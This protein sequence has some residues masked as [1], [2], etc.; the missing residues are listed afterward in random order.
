MQPLT[1]H[2]HVSERL[3]VVDQPH[4]LVDLRGHLLAKLP[5]LIEGHTAA[6]ATRAAPRTEERESRNGNKK[7]SFEHR[8]KPP[9][10]HFCNVRSVAGAIVCV[11]IRGV[12]DYGPRG[13]RYGCDWLG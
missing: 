10:Q 5:L 4:L 8:P 11:A 9:R 7:T 1:D 3:P 6:Q 2:P 12:K 13:F